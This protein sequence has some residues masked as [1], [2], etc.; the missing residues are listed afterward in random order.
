[1]FVCVGLSATGRTA[2]VLLAAAVLAAAL[3]ITQPRQSRQ[4]RARGICR[5]CPRHGAPL[6]DGSALFSVI[7]LVE[8]L[9]P[10][11]LAT[12]DCCVSST[13][14]AWTTV[15]IIAAPIVRTAVTNLASVVPTGAVSVVVLLAALL[16]AV[17][18]V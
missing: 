12:F 18:V 15:V 2:E 17:D 11:L 1:M 14:V 5:I 8:N 13:A 6:C 3:T 4:G 7:V 10:V 16:V 9:I